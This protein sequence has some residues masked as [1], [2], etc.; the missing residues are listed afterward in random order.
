[1][2]KKVVIIASGQTEAAALPRLLRCLEPD[3]VVDEVRIPSSNRD[4]SV[5]VIE[6]LI[7]AAWFVKAEDDRP[8]KFIVVVDV[9]KREPAEVLG[10]IQEDLHGRLRDVTADVQYAY[11]QQHLEAWYFAD[12]ENLK[13]YLGG[14]EPGKINASKSGRYPESETASQECTVMIRDY[15][16]AHRLDHGGPD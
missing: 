4:L 2:P 1:M 11:A 13:K 16:Q 3:I 6:S 12:V 14:R 5:N 15:R 9:D 7:R 8:H 10:P